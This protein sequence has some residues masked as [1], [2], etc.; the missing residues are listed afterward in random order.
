MGGDEHAVEIADLAESEKEGGAFGGST[1]VLM[2]GRP[3]FGTRLRDN[4]ASSAPP[5]CE[6]IILKK[7]LSFRKQKQHSPSALEKTR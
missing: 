6:L 5:W 4:R 1:T 2:A 3:P 7:S